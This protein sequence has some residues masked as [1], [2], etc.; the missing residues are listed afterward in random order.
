[1]ISE[2]GPQNLH[3][4]ESDEAAFMRLA[5]DGAFL[6]A[7]FTDADFRGNSQV[8]EINLPNTPFSQNRHNHDP[9]YEI[10]SELRDM[11]GGF[12]LE[13]LIQSP[14]AGFL[15]PTKDFPSAEPLVENTMAATH[16]LTSLYHALKDRSA[17]SLNYRAIIVNATSELKA[18]LLGMTQFDLEGGINRSELPHILGACIEAEKA[19]AAHVHQM[20]ILKSGLA[21]QGE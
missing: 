1:M 21:S 15:E 16:G 12:V 14:K 7:R 19:M 6:T 20:D 11:F 9:V 5:D 8:A 18:F 4:A 17:L 10:I 2:H 13:N 3:S